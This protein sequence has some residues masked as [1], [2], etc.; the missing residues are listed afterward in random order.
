MARAPDV[1][2]RASA[3]DELLQQRLDEM[4]GAHILGLFLHPANL[5]ASRVLL[6]ELCDLVGW[7]GVQLLEPHERDV[8]GGVLALLAAHEI[9]I[10]LAA[11]Q[12]K[13][14]NIA[15]LAPG[16]VVIDRELETSV[17]ELPRCRCR[18]W[19]TQEA[20]R[21]E[22][23]ERQRIGREK[24]RLPA[25]QVEVLRCRRA[26]CDAHVEVGGAFQ[27]PLQPSTRVVR[28]LPFVP[29]RQEHRQRSGE[30]PLGASRRDE[31]VENDLRPVDEVAVLRL[32]EHET[33][34]CL[35]AV[36][37]LEPERRVLGERAVV[38]LE[39]RA[40]PRKR[41]ERNVFS[42]R[43]RIVKHGM[44][45]TEGASLDILAS[46]TNG[47]AVF[48]DAS[49]RKLLG[50]RPVDGPIDRLIQH[51]GTP[52]TSAFEFAMHG[53][54]FGQRQQLAIERHEPFE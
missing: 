37:E 31:L 27:K 33:A 32:P 39:G 49:E 26:V 24:Q 41:S 45:M 29:V 52:L 10:D 2:K 36:A 19:M 4:P 34:L 25:E 54:S 12:K 35:N 9:H 7:K 18:E 23:D 17:G 3:V 5:D 22:D 28:S 8:S 53:K 20:F 14:S 48:E 44:P 21:R 47:Y 13:A 51:R 30:P 38:D 42:A 40:C 15:R 16:F 6:D 46:E 43:D 11:A 50:G 1:A